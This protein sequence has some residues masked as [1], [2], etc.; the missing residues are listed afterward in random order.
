[1]DILKKLTIAALELH[2]FDHVHQWADKIFCLEPNFL[3]AYTNGWCKDTVD[4]ATE[5]MYAAYYC[6][7]VALQRQGNI[8]SAISD[9][10]QALVC[11]DACH[12]TYYQLHALRQ[13]NAKENS[14]PCIEEIKVQE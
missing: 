4:W 1:M 2:D 6:S 8:D 7:A 3:E 9:F 14:E 12:A 13:V 10:E 11:D 5:A